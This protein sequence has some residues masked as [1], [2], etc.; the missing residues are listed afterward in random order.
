MATVKCATATTMTRKTHFFFLFIYCRYYQGTN[1]AYYFIIYYIIGNYYYIVLYTCK[2]IYVLN[3]K[4]ARFTINK[5]N[6]N[7]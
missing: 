2:N 1:W 7:I 4:R 3:A 5:T 6:N